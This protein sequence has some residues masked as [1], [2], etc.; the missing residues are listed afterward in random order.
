MEFSVSI[1]RACISRRI[2]LHYYLRQTYVLCRDK[3][4]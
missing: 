4:M 1:T 3:K 2:L